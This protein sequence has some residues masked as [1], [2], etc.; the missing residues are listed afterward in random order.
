MNIKIEKNDPPHSLLIQL[1]GNQ[2]ISA[3]TDE[4]MKTNLLF[5]QNIFDEDSEND[6]I[7]DSNID[8]LV[9][10]F[11]NTP[12]FIMIFFDELFAKFILHPWIQIP[13]K[14]GKYFKMLKG[15]PEI[16]KSNLTINELFLHFFFRRVYNK[17]FAKGRRLI[18]TFMETLVEKEIIDDKLHETYYNKF[19]FPSN[20]GKIEYQNN[21]IELKGED[22]EEQIKMQEEEKITKLLEEIIIKGDN[23]DE[24]NKLI[25]E[26]DI[27]PNPHYIIYNK[28]NMTDSIV[29]ILPDPDKN[30]EDIAQIIIENTTNKEILNELSSKRLDWL[31]EEGNLQRW[32]VIKNARIEKNLQTKKLCS[33]LSK[34]YE[35]EIYILSFK[36][37]FINALFIY[38]KEE[39]I[40]FS[41][42]YIIKNLQ[43]IK[44]ERSKTV[45]SNY[46]KNCIKYENKNKI[47]ERINNAIKYRCFKFLNLCIETDLY[48]EKIKEIIS[49]EKNQISFIKTAIQYHNYKFLF[50]QKYSEKYLQQKA[51]NEEI[52]KENY[53]K[54]Q[55][56]NPLIQNVGWKFWFSLPCLFIEGPSFGR[57][58]FRKDV[59]Y[60]SNCFSEFFSLPKDCFDNEKFSFKLHDF[61]HSTFK[62]PV[63]SKMFKYYS[64]EN[65]KYEINV[66]GKQNIISPEH[67]WKAISGQNLA[68]V[69]YF[70]DEY[71]KNPNNPKFSPFDHTANGCFPLLYNSISPKLLSLLRTHELTKDIYVSKSEKDNEFQIGYERFYNFFYHHFD[72]VSKFIL[73]TKRDVLYRPSNPKRKNSKKRKYSQLADHG[74]ELLKVIFQKLSELH[75]SSSIE[76]TIDD[77]KKS[78]YIELLKAIFKSKKSLIFPYVEY[79]SDCKKK[80]KTVQ[81]KAECEKRKYNLEDPKEKEIMLKMSSMPSYYLTIDLFDMIDKSKQKIEPLINFYYVLIESLTKMKNTYE[82]A[83]IFK[84]LMKNIYECKDKTQ[85]NYYETLN[86]SMKNF[87]KHFLSVLQ[88]RTSTKKILTEKDIEL[89]ELYKKYYDSIP[90]DK[91]FNNIKNCIEKKIQKQS[92]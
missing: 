26:S 27:I 47:P 48:E 8:R 52:L 25:E 58:E 11:K 1:H 65:I 73:N 81:Q 4:K 44:Y 91:K 35:K 45:S 86:K 54:V 68:V 32:K 56:I 82:Q 79:I 90:L 42:K 61:N 29:L 50:E 53:D 55:K 66:E 20:L 12:E 85:S 6:Y 28:E 15:K 57:K 75:E 7:N 3:K 77:S 21:S 62:C 13:E 43:N 63:K 70:L 88:V 71:K 51:I 31:N 87:C 14:F 22:E 18:L 38:N 10:L 60:D 34:F 24:L 67:F 64:V 49:N 80:S 2:Q 17:D 33:F 92:K 76:Q 74:E 39:W 69:K 37:T 59:D 72:D 19:Q 5:L 23:K 9:D 36:Y 16:T 89:F 83:F 84:T 78:E 41:N 30:K 40:D 46:I